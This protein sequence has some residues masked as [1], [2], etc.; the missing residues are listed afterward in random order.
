MK[1]SEKNILLN[2]EV[3]NKIEILKLLS[4]YAKSIDITD[5][6]QQL[7]FD[8]MEREKEGMTGFQNT[9][10]IPHAKSLAIKKP[11]VIYARNN[12]IIND[13]ETF[14]NVGVKHIFA[15]L[16]PKN[17]QGTVHIEML[18]KLATALMEEEFIEKLIKSD[19]EKEIAM[20]IENGMNGDY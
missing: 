6:S 7:F 15:L 8:F 1:F 9:F 14:D 5:D 3:K 12:T 11:T 18:S 10:A 17:E 2:C 20:I 4:N 16:V 19:N 13:W